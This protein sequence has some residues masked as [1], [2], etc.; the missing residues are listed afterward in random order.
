M[1]DLLIL[2]EQHQW[3]ELHATQTFVGSENAFIAFA[4]DCQKEPGSLICIYDPAELYESSSLLRQDALDET[5]WKLLMESA[6]D[7]KWNPF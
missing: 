2:A 1:S 4:V 7:L 6:P 3:K 5:Q